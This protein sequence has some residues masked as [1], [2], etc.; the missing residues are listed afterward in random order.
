VI[1]FHARCA[2]ET[3]RRGRT[4]VIFEEQS[5]EGLTAALH[6]Y[7]S[8]EFESSA[9]RSHFEGSGEPQYQR[10]MLVVVREVTITTAWTPDLSPRKPSNDSC[11]LHPT[12]QSGSP[13]R[14]HRR[15]ED[16]AAGCSAD[17]T[18]WR[19]EDDQGAPRW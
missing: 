13:L 15:R 19:Q 2:A 17:D 10:R 18:G 11:P 6:G 16:K 4:C 14:I 1:A 5:V 7:D 9:I 12:K 3:L 8:D